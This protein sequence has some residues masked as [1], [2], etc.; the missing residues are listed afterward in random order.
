MEKFGYGSKDES[1]EGPVC[2]GLCLMRVFDMP[3]YGF[4][5]IHQLMW[6]S[7]ASTRESRPFSRILSC[8]LRQQEL[9]SVLKAGEMLY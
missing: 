7:S 3:P 2:G 6:K 9:C 8:Q 4:L 1:R 5:I